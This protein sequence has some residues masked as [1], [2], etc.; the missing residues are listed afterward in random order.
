MH[1]QVR[2]NRLN[3]TLLLLALA[4]TIAGCGSG[5]VVYESISSAST[6]PGP[7]KAEPSAFAAAAI[8]AAQLSADVEDE[9]HIYGDPTYSPAMNLRHFAELAARSSQRLQAAGEAGVAEALEARLRRELAHYAAD[10]DAAAR[11]SEANAGRA[12]TVALAATYSDGA[13]MQAHAEQL[14]E[15][16]GASS[17]EAH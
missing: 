14:A 4:A 15:L 12:E 1:L 2:P 6:F 16:T 5:G 11:A 3:L 10:L 17:V 9:I 7:S 13:Q 8:E